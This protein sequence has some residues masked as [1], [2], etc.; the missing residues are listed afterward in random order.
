MSKIKI[1]NDRCPLQGECEQKQCE[2][3]F[4]E[5]DCSYYQGN[6]RPGAEIEDQQRAMEAEWE[7]RMST[8]SVLGDTLDAPQESAVAQGNASPLVLLPIDRLCPHPDNPRKDLGDLTELADSIKVN[9]ILQNLT[10][11]KHYGEISGEWNGL[12]RV[13]IGHRRLAAAKM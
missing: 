3:K 5:R 7:A 13:I 12:Y 2:Y 10:V 9:G 1:I 8:P 11:V 4:R 6:A